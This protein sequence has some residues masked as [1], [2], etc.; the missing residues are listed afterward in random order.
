MKK[1]IL[2]VG[3]VI[4]LILAI[5]WYKNIISEPLVAVGSGIL[6]LLT[7]IFVPDNDDK[8]IKTKITQKHY[9]KGD[10]VAGNKIIKK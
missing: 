2:I 7:L 9:G 8:S 4:T 5:L 6:T 3:S 1:I 10:N